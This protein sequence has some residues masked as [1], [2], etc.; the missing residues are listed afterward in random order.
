MLEL[1]FF[2]SL[3]PIRVVIQFIFL[4][5]LYLISKYRFIYKSKLHNYYGMKINKA[6]LKLFSLLMPF[7][8]F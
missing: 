2:I 4:L 7:L 5:E 6:G 3:I 1:I 8:I